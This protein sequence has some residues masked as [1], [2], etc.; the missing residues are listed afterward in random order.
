MACRLTLVSQTNSKAAGLL[1]QR[2]SDRFI[3]FESFA[4]GV[5]ALECALSSLTSSLVYSL[6]LLFVFFAT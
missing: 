6:R 3:S 4:T 2:A 5:R 1:S